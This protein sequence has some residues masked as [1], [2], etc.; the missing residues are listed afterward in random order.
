MVTCERGHS[1]RRTPGVECPECHGAP[2]ESQPVE[3]APE[4][5]V[6]APSTDLISREPAKAAPKAGRST[7]ADRVAVA[8]VAGIVVLVAVGANWDRISSELGLGTTAEAT[9]IVSSP[10]TSE[11]A[12]PSPVDSPTTTLDPD[13][14]WETGACV[15]ES[16]FDGAVSVVSCFGSPDGEILATPAFEGACPIRTTHVVE[17]DTG[18]AC[19][20][21][22]WAEGFNAEHCTFNGMPLYGDV[23]FT[24]SSFGYHMSIAPLD[25]TLLADLQVFAVENSREA[26]SCGL[27]HVVDSASEADLV[28]AVTD[29][30]LFADFTI[31][32]AEFEW[33]AGT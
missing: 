30:E 23:F 32:G 16:T 3:K 7:R 28:I 19:L 1:Y 18:V 14:G 20:L 29:S 31:A 33:E 9:G 12:A 13:V 21:L 25:S 27:W 17:L 24:E 10:V 15:E 4:S 5:N 8:W 22:H 11:P 26:D 6:A 2:V